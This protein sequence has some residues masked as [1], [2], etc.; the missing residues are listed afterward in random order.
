M[1]FDIRGYPYVSDTALDEWK[2]GGQSAR[3]V[4]TC[5]G[6][7]STKLKALYGA[8]LW[9]LRELDTV[10]DCLSHLGIEVYVTSR[11]KAKQLVSELPVY[12][13]PRLSR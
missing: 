13:D 1:R 7:M 4:E 5:E 8:P 10:R 6:G 11:P 2:E 3:C 12:G 9:T